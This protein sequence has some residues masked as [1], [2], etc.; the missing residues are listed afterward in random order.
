MDVACFCGFRHRLIGDLGI[1]P[2]CG[3]YV[4]LNRVSD[5]EASQ[6]RAELDLLLHEGPPDAGSNVS[7]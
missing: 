6:M 5:A 7:V 1:C 4:T 2:R 3:D